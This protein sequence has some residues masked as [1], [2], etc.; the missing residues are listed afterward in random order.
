MGSEPTRYGIDVDKALM[1]EETRKLMKRL[2]QDIDPATQLGYL[3]IGQ[4]QVVE[5]AKALAQK[6]RFLILDEPTSAL[7][8]AEADVLFRIIRELTSQGVGIVYISHRLE[9]LIKIGD[10]ITVLRDG[11]VTGNAPDARAST[12]PWIVEAMIGGKSKDFSEDIDHSFGAEVFPSRRC[13]PA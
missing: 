2:E 1:I 8:S 3:R 13:Q 7:S 10:Y 5:I 9:E 6:A 12:S 4:Q 11:Q